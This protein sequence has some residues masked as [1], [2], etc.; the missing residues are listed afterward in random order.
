M[1]AGQK[2]LTEKQYNILRR[3]GT[4]PAFSGKYYY[5]YEVGT[6]V[7]AACGNPLFSSSHKFDCGCGWP[8]FDASIPG[9]VEFVPDYSCGMKRI[10]VL[11]A[12]C[13]S[14]LGHVFDDGPTSTGTRY[15]INSLA[16]DFHKKTKIISEN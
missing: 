9:S 13:H 11:C 16:L 8:S 14:H 2:V 5:F 15:C 12:N 1:M 7:C 3:K 10:E 4:E 6:F